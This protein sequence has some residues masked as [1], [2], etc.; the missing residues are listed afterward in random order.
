M[1]THQG[2]SASAGNLQT[3]AFGVDGLE[4]PLPDG[5]S[6]REIIWPKEESAT[7]TRK[8]GLMP[9]TSTSSS[10]EACLFDD[11]ALRT[12]PRLSPRITMST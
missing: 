4:L 6:P 5:V 11:A 12:L 8:A 3:D 2:I 9:S 10:C 7:D 1:T